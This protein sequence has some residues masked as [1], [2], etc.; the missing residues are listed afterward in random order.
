MRTLVLGVD[1]GNT[2]TD[3]FLADGSGRLVAFRRAGT[4]SQEHF[5]DH[6][7]SAYRIMHEEIRAL[8]SSMSLSVADISACVFGLAGVDTPHQKSALERVVTRFGFKK[9]LIVNDCFIPIKAGTTSGVGV[10]VINGTGTSVGA[11]DAL[12]TMLQVGGLG[13]LTSDFAGGH[14]IARS[15]VRA[16]YDALYKKTRMT[17]LVE[18]A[19]ALYGTRDPVLFMQEIAEQGRLCNDPRLTLACFARAR[20]GDEIAREILTTIGTTLGHSALG[21]VRSLSFTGTVEIVLAGS[22]WIK[23]DSSDMKDAFSRVLREEGLPFVLRPLSVPPATGALLWALELANGR[24]PDHET[25]EEVFASVSAKLK[26][27]EGMR[28]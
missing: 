4:C 10:S 9:T 24:V 23:G 7:E 19:T 2:K 12:G 13:E 16:A 6:E 17:A 3:Y 26:E 8:L 21:A 27:I 22:V 20:E 28:S 1:G 5:P 25:R 14:Y 18:D 11:V 15:V